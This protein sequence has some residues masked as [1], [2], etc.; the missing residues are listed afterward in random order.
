MTLNLLNSYIL[1]DAGNFVLANP[2]ETLVF[3][4]KNILHLH[5]LFFNQFLID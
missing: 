5:M 3:N 4:R 1:G 2:L